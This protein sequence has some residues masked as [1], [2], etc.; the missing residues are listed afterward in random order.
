M[1]VSILALLLCC[2]ATLA[3]GATLDE[4]LIGQWRSELGSIIT[5]GADHSYVDRGQGVVRIG[6]WHTR[7]HRLTTATKSPPG[8]TEYINTCD[9]LLRG[10]E[11]CFGMCEHVERLHGNTSKPELYTTGIVYK[12]LRR[13]YQR[14]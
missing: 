11:F 8:P 2:S 6:M 4:Q 7:E 5:F 13:S 3:D 1:L 12:R 10:D 14:I 9:V